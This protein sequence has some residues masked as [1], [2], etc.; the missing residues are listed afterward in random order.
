MQ[1]EKPTWVNENEKFAL[2]GLHVGH[3]NLSSQKIENS[4]LWVFTDTLRLESESMDWWKET[5]GTNWVG[6]IF[7]CN[8]FL[9]S[10]S[11]A[12]AP[13]ILDAQNDTLQRRVEEFYLGLLLS[14]MF[15]PWKPPIRITGTYLPR[16][17]DIPQVCTLECPLVS[18]NQCNNAITPNDITY[19][20][21]LAQNLEKMH[22]T[23]NMGF[24][25]LNRILSVYRRARLSREPLDRIHQYVRCLDG[26]TLVSRQ[27]R[28]RSKEFSKRIAKTFIGLKPGHF[29]LVKELYTIRSHT[30]HLDERKYLEKWNRKTILNL[31]EK[32]AGNYIPKS[33]CP[34]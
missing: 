25:Q 24:W 15:A 14:S 26:L 28:S 7:R 23:T 6:N 5:L 27:T 9:V 13:G 29:D 18:I 34:G 2:I 31:V 4:N 19:A 1:I 10:K 3:E 20:A 22:S 21:R 32:E 17:M 16:G 8:L 11:I 12:K 30:E 33:H